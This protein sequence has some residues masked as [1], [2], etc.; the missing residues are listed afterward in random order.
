MPLAPHPRRAIGGI[1]AGVVALALVVGGFAGVL[2]LRSRDSG[3]NGANT[4][5]ATAILNAAASAPLRD[6]TF[7]LSGAITDNLP[8]G[9]MYKITLSGT[10]ALT[11]SPQRLH[12]TA[13][14]ENKGSFGPSGSLG[15]EEIITDGSNTYLKM[16]GTPGNSNNGQWVKAKSSAD[17]NTPLSGVGF[18]N[19]RQLGNPVVI[20]A[21]TIGGQLTW[22]VR[23]ALA[24]KDIYPTQSSSV[25]ITG[26]EDLWLAQSTSFPVRVVQSFTLGGSVSGLTA[27]NAFAVTITIDFT[28]WNT[29]VT[30]TPPASYVNPGSGP[31]HP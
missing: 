13:A 11:M 6:A 7:N 31:V 29:G 18:L 26:T 19:Y 28:A 12:Y 10:G 23:V 3:A 21:E 2:A 14:I 27:A 8:G 5:Q 25:R 30:I 20:G 15:I 17:G 9:N 16:S 1:V 22:H 4:A 24:S